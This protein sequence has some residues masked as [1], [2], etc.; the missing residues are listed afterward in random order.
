MIKRLL[1]L[2]LIFTFILLMIPCGTAM[3][4]NDTMSTLVSLVNRFPHGEYWN[5][6]GKSNDPDGVTLTPCAGH[7]NCNWGVNSCDC[8]SF[9]NAIQCMGYAHKIS[10]EITG[11]MPRNNY[12]K[13]TTLKASELRVGDIIRYRWNGHSI[14]V[15][16]VDDDVISFTDCNYIGRCQIRW[17]TMNIADIVGFSYV[18]R[19]KGNNRKNSDLYFYENTDGYKTEID[20]EA[21]SEIWQMSDSSLNLRS[22]RKITANILGKIPAGARF[23]IYDKYYDGTYIWGKVVYGDLM[24]WCALNYSEYLEGVIESPDIKNIDEAYT[25]G[26][27]VKL[28]WNEVSGATKYVIS[29]YNS[30]GKRVKK[31]TV[32]RK[33]EKSITIDK[34]G[35]Y[36]AK[37]VAGSSIIPSWEIESKA[38]SFDIVKTSNMVSVESVWF[39]APEKM[40]KGSTSTLEVT[41]EPAWAT[42]GAVTWKSS[43]TSVATVNSKGKITAKNIGTATITCTAVD[44]STVSYSQKITVVPDKVKNISQA[45]STSTSV[46]LKWSKVSDASVYAIYRYSDE[47]GKYE[48]IDTTETNSYTMKASSGKTYKIRVRAIGEV[49]SKSY[50]AENS[51]VFTAVSGPKAPTLTAKAGEKQVTLRWNKVSGA[52]H[53]VI[54]EIKDGGKVKLVTENADNTDFTYTVPELTS[55]T[56]TYKIR[57]IKKVG[58]LK[59]YGSYSKAVTVKVQ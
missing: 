2:M 13:H 21:S 8:N 25:L 48:K 59:G 50:Y 15:T 3:G 53:Y 26:E 42:E 6:V 40:A 34:E 20:T 37:V 38:Y 17:D 36:T 19:L 10:Y 28:Q 31:H 12:V 14:C 49:L 24:G 16:G 39:C 5:H 33:T 18:L 29:I 30:D 35:K 41:V 45:S 52:T 51:D 44:D 1:C 47:T 4:A 7:S 9:D 23:H 57:A 32:G 22:T 46:T 11:V 56:Y 55:G 43:D 27:A 54:Y 58:S